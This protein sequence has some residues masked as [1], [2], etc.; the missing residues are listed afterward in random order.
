MVVVKFEFVVAD[1]FVVAME[2]A[3]YVGAV[4]IE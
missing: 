3:E 2:V 4:M 1:T